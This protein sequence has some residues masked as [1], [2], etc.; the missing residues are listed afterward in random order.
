MI[1]PYLLVALWSVALWSVALWSVALS[2]A[3][4]FGPGVVRTAQADEMKLNAVV[5]SVN[6]KALTLKDLQIKAKLSS[7]PKIEEITADSKLSKALDELI[8]SAILQEEANERQISV[9]ESDITRYTTD[10]AAQNGL[11]IDEFKKALRQEGLTLTEYQEQ[12]KTELLKTKIAG[13]MFRE[14]MGVSDSEIE[15]YLEQH[16][17]LAQSGDKVKIRHL[18]V[19][20]DGKSEEDLNRIVKKIEEGLEDGDDFQDLV[21]KYSDQ[22]DKSEGGYLGIFA[23]AD[24]SEDIQ[25]AILELDEEESSDKIETPSSIKYF[26]LEERM[27]SETDSTVK[28]DVRKILENEKMEEKLTKYFS[29]DMLKK[30]SVEKKI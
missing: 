21:K 18:V 26:F 20:K 14:G 28:E 22:D 29:S 5:A 23:V 12:V 11:S 2:T 25:T 8:M 1:R 27:S 13:S 24:L 10:I 15:K 3:L 19:N 6:G 9:R 17:S 30:Y 7:L 16:P 4:L